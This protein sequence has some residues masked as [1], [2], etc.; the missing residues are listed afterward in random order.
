MICRTGH[1]VVSEK[2]VQRGDALFDIVYVVAV[3][4]RTV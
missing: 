2:L 3:H 4:D 1:N